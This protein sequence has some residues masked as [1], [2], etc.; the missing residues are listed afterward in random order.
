MT[1]NRS[2]T[3]CQHAAKNL[4]VLD[5]GKSNFAPYSVLENAVSD[6]QFKKVFLVALKA[7]SDRVS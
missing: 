5:T 2:P 6:V 3:D 7:A 4:I 1:W